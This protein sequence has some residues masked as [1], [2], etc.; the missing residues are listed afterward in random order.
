MKDTGDIQRHGRHQHP[1]SL[2]L[3]LDRQ[4]G[5]NVLAQVD[6]LA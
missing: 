2:P 6:A 3:G 1:E 4:K 5:Q